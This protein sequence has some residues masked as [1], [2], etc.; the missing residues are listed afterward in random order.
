MSEMFKIKKAKLYGLYDLPKF[1]SE[2]LFYY[3]HLYIKGELDENIPF[4]MIANCNTDIETVKKISDE[5][6]SNI[7]E[8]TDIE[9]LPSFNDKDTDD[10]EQYILHGAEIKILVVH[11]KI[12]AIGSMNSKI[13]IST[14]RFDERIDNLTKFMNEYHNNV[15]FDELEEIAEQFRKSSWVI[16]LIEDGFVYNKMN[17]AKEFFDSMSLQEYLDK[18]SE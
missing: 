12:I 8:I 11:N 16:P 2:K 7:L 10:N 4:I 1:N 5:I 3:Q 18:L 17:D 9:N 14:Q 6:S 13:W 15:I